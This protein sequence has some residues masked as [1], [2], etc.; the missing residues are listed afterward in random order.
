MSTQPIDAS[1]ADAVAPSVS[2]GLKDLL[3]E[4]E[5]E[6]IVKALADSGGHQ[7]RAARALG[8][9]PTTLNEKMRR[10]NLRPIRGGSESGFPPEPPR[11]TRG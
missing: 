9:L 6:L 3:D 10:L 11:P 7:R 5:R 8:V 2:R 4:Y 1:P